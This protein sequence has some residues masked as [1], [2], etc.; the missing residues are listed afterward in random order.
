M[1]SPSIHFE[2]V[3][4]AF[5]GTPLFEQF[6]AEMPAGKCTCL[7]GP[8]GCGK[9]TILGLISGNTT[10]KFSGNIHFL[11]KRDVVPTIGWMAQKDL[12]LPWLTVRD[13]VLL[14]AKLRGEVTDKLIKKADGLLD[15]AG[16]TGYGAS[17]P[18]ELSGGMRQRTALL[19]TLMEERSIILMDEP[20]SALDALTRMKLQNMSARMTRGRTVLMVTHDPLEALRL[21]DRILVLGGKPVQVISVIDVETRSPRDPQNIEVQSIYPNLLKQL[22]SEVSA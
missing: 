19:R 22:M 13:N 16:L 5:N 21:A 9:S 7:L 12:L 8:S 3:T 6:S 14:G 11:P 18:A 10:L 2:N 20:F 15:D 1:Q 4:L 17:L